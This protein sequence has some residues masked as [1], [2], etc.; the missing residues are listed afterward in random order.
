[1]KTLHAKCF[2]GNNNVESKWA[3]TVKDI[4]RKRDLAFAVLA[5]LMFIKMLFVTR[6]TDD[7]PRALA[8]SQ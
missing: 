7:T 8:Y 4:Q 1:M 2:R 6:V 5:W 3:Y